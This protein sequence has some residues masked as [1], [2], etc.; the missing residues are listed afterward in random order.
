MDFT[1]KRGKQGEGSSSFTCSQSGPCANCLEE[2]ER[3]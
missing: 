1:G 3:P 2:K